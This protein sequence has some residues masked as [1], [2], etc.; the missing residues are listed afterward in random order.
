M[1]DRKIKGT[2][3]LKKCSIDNKLTGAFSPLTVIMMIHRRNGLFHRE[4][5]SK[6]AKK[7]KSK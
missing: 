6:Q 5:F 2:T 3:R 7:C 4:V 1:F